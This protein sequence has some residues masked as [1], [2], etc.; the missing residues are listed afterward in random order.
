MK[1]FEEVADNTLQEI[2]DYLEEVDSLGS[3]EC[4]LIDGILTIEIVETEQQFVVN[5]HQ[6]SNQI[7][8]SSPI[9]GGS[10][11]IYDE[12]EETWFDSENNDLDEMLKSEVK[13]LADL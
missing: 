7:W 2:I 5:K 6:S 8:C 11:F 10:N 12:N 4:D 9:S 1:N 3:L 13:S